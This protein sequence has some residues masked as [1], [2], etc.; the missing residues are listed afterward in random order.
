MSD[1]YKRYLQDQDQKTADRRL[2]SDARQAL[3]NF[4]QNNDAT[5]FPNLEKFI[6]HQNRF[7][8]QKLTNFGTAVS[9]YEQDLG[10]TKSEYEC[11]QKAF[12]TLS[13]NKDSAKATLSNGEVV[14]L[15]LNTVCYSD[16]TLFRLTQNLILGVAIKDVADPKLYIWYKQNTNEY[17]Y[18]MEITISTEST[19][20]NFLTCAILGHIGINQQARQECIVNLGYALKNMEDE[21]CHSIN[22]KIPITIDRY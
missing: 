7:G 13:A 3:Y 16:Q 6:K 11:F 8:D 19:N 17:Q 22:L 1:K 14:N 5:N 15:D 21:S 20:T 4:R 2:V 9:R 12:E 18:M 10:L